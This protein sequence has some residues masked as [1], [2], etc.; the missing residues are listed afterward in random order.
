LEQLFGQLVDYFSKAFINEKK[1]FS[2]QTLKEYRETVTPNYIL[3][4]SMMLSYVGLLYILG[5]EFEIIKYVLLIPMLFCAFYVDLKKQIIP[6]RLNLLMF[7]IGL[8]I[9]FI[10]GISNL[11][12]AINMLLG[13]LAGGGIFLAITII[14]GLIAGKEAMGLRRCKI[15]GSTSDYILV[16]KEL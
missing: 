2:K 16:C 6:N 5:I 3:V 12:I 1:I 8:V 11:N 7:E 14:G 15:N 10:S 9:V 13:M 4:V